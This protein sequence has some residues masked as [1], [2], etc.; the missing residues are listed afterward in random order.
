MAS[1]D[2][3]WVFGGIALIAGALLG[4]LICRR[5]TPTITDV[6]ELRVKLERSRTEMEDYRASVNGHFSKTSDLVKELTEDYVKVYRHLSEGAQT[7]SDAPEFTHV[8]EQQK[9]KLLISVDDEASS[10]DIGDTR[11]DTR[12]DARAEDISA[13]GDQAEAASPEETPKETPDETQK[14]SGSGDSR[15]ADDDHEEPL[16]DADVFE[17]TQADDDGREKAAAGSASKEDKRDPM[18]RTD[19]Q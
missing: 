8:L 5:F 17:P 18:A 6:D 3:V 12:V 13:Q 7:L 1:I 19:T 2:P 15:L 11:Q 14:V 4:A 16:T 9:G 10:P